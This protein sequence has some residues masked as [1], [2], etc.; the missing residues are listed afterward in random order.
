M[1][2]SHLLSPYD[3]T[4][5]L[6]YIVSHMAEEEFLKTTLAGFLPV[7]LPRAIHHGIKVL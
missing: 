3:M 4:R 2:Q 5:L 7:V 1:L 6:S